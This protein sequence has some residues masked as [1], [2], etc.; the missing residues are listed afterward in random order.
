[1]QL[2]GMTFR[3]VVLVIIRV[4]HLGIKDLGVALVSRYAGNGS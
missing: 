2:L 4:L 3:M 1:M